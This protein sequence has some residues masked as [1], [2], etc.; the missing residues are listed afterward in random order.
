MTAIAA[1]ATA[2]SAATSAAAG[3]ATQLAGDM[4]NFLRMLTTQLRNQ[5]PQSPMDP[6]QF[7]AQLA[8]F[9]AVEQQI[10]ANRHMEEML[11]LQRASSM[12]A[13]A[14]LLGRNVEVASDRLALQ[15]GQSAELRL[16]A[17]ADANGARRARILITDSQDRT[18]R[19]AFADLAGT[20]SAWRWDGRDSRGRALADGSYKVTVTGV[21][22]QGASRGT[23]AHGVTGTVTAVT[24]Q[25]GDP[26]LSVGGLSVGLGALRGLR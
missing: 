23:L 14:P 26:T 17:I 25:D 13:A 8:Q 15:G 10:A 22:A 5:D 16:P 19:E 11:S 3:A 18:L 12:L 20:A 7:T 2:A 1:A 9:A 4:T 21:D 24:R 6:N